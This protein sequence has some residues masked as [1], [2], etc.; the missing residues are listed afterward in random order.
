MMK[1]Q[2]KEGPVWVNPD[3]IISLRDEGSFVTITTIFGGT[4]YVTEN[5]AERI[6]N[7]INGG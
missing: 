4:I 6:A 3:H 2:T 7:L 1:L 5:K